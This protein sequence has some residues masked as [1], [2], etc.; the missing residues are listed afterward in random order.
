MRLWHKDLISVLPNKQLVAQWRE[1]CGIIGSIDKKGTP[2]H[3]LVNKV[4]DYPPIHF[5]MYTNVVLEE[6][7]S[8]GFSVSE[9]A[10]TRMSNL[11]RENLD[12]FDCFTFQYVPESINDIYKD[13]HNDRY[14]VQC[15]YNLQ[16][17]YDCGMISKEDYEK[18]IDKYVELFGGRL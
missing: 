9:S 11:F 13:W 5:I 3:P 1:L 7:R 16:E 18:L 17:K 12:K 15:F 8:R 4:I 14:F 2:N 10:Y 6:M